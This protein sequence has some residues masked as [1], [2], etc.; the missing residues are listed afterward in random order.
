M[1][2]LS[3]V[4]RTWA[5]EIKD[6]LKKAWWKNTEL[7]TWRSKVWKKMDTWRS[8]YSN[9]HITHVQI[10]NEERNSS[11]K[12]F[13]HH[14]HRN[15]HTCTSWSRIMTCF[16]LRI[17]SLTQQHMWNR[18]AFNLSPYHELHISLF[19]GRRKWRQHFALVRNPKS[20]KERSRE[21]TKELGLCLILK[22][23]KTQASE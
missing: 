10:K 4:T 17:R 5:K 16:L 1:T 18:Y 14:P 11:W 12:E 7:D 23:Y 13:T 2:I 19:K 22:T 15:S 9:I 21:Q 6:M 20:K 3:K 8:K